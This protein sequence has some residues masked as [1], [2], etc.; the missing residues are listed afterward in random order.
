MSEAWYKEW[1]PGCDAIN[2]IC[3]GNENDLSGVDIEAIKC[4]KCGLIWY[5]GDPDNLEFDLE[6]IGSKNIEDLNW[7][8][9]LEKPE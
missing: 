1:C 6:M 7:E 8:I 9:G 5:L 3:N 2:W 4:R